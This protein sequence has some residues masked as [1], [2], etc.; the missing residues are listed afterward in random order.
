LLAKNHNVSHAES[1]NSGLYFALVSYQRIRADQGTAIID[2]VMGSP[3]NKT[4]KYNG[5]FKTALARL[6][7]L[8]YSAAE[9]KAAT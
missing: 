3:P 4:H 8:V 6:G 7:A 5:C 1:G 9:A 2:F